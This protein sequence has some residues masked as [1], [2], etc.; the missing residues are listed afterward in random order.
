MVQLW[1]LYTGQSPVY[2]QSPV[3]SR[4]GKRTTDRSPCIMNNEYITNDERLVAV[5]EFK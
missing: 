2:R 1:F 3:V 5:R 4:H